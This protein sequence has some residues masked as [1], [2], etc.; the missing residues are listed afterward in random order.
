MI[1][2]AMIGRARLAAL[3]ATLLSGC[4]LYSARGY[5]GPVSDHFDGEAFYNEGVEAPEGRFLRFLG[6]I[7][8]RDQGPWPEVED[9]TPGP[10]PPHRVGPGELRVT[11]VNHATVLVQMD[12][13]NVLTD[14]VWSEGVGPESLEVVRRVRPPGL[15]FED[16]PPID[17]VLLS[18]NHYDHMDLPT[19]RR[20]QA[21]HAPR[22]AAGLGS[23]DIL[24][25]AGVRS[26]KDFD[27]W[28]S[29][30]VSGTVRLT[31][32]PVQHF[33]MRG[34]CDRDKVLWTGFVLEGPAGR[35]YFGGDTGYGPHFAEVGQRFGPMRLAVLP[36]GA[37]RPRWFMSHVHIDPAEAL[38][39]ALDLR[40][41]T[42]VGMHFGTFKQADDGRDEPIAD[43][44]RALD[45][46]GVSRERFWVLGF[47][48][49][50]DVPP[51]EVAVQPAEV[52]PWPKS[53]ASLAGCLDGVAS[54]FP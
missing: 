37:Y 32:V 35:V 24:R 44:H 25:R 22:I 42:A 47:G 40:A 53:R 38:A 9:V 48:E 50:R 21:E 27:W 43:L 23:A 18:H 16:L 54:A 10:P 29:A 45:E 15:R 49:G 34:V 5:R 11:F 20:L 52:P 46:A 3:A 36:I 26:A 6:W 17:L 28:Q 2:R 14:P 13:I 30:K 8:N 1:G 41:A 51:L 4:C 19:L 12:G 7:L 31:S 39:A 33:S